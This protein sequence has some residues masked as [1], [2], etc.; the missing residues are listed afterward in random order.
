[1]YSYFDTKFKKSSTNLAPGEFHV[2]GDD[3]II[4]TVL[5]SCV[6]VAIY[7]P[8]L[9]ISGLNHFMLAES[10]F[11]HQNESFFNIERYGLYAM[12]AVLNDM[13]KRGCRKGRLQAKIFGGSSVFETRTKSNIG[14]ANIEFAKLYLK[15][16]KI[17]VISSDT[18]GE[19]ARR[20]YLFPQTFK[21]LLRRIIPTKELTRQM[22]DYTKNLEHDAGSGSKTVIFGEDS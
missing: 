12:E 21:V 7:D 13:I 14:P 11:Q 19:Q 4:N 17:P 6:A 9:R 5:G 1:M 10:N 20:I 8:E 2:S 18:G 22:Q 3:I 15:T 16:E